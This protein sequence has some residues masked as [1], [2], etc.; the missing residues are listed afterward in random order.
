MSF[1]KVKITAPYAAT[2]PVAGADLLND[3]PNPLYGLITFLNDSVPK[4]DR[5]TLDGILYT[6]NAEVLLGMLTVSLMQTVSGVSQS[7][8][9]GP[10]EFYQVPLFMQIDLAE[11]VPDHLRLTDEEGNPVDRTWQQY[12]D[13]TTGRSPLVIGE[14][15]YTGV[16]DLSG[17]YLPFSEAVALGVTLLTKPE[18]NYLQSESEI[19]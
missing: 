2:F 10:V 13:E 18:I 14:N 7:T 3:G 9:G 17:E 4:K 1:H 11:N 6:W 16:I 15:T 19:E 12:F 8:Y 5:Y